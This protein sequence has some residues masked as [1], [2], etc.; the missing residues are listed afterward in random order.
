MRHASMAMSCVAE[1]K[2]DENGKDRNGAEA[3]RGIGTRHQPESQHDQTLAHEHPRPA[4]PEPAGQHGHPRA[5]DERRPEELERGNQR[6]QA[7]EA[8]HF[9]REAGGAQPRRQRV[10]DEIVR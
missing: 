8:D 5:I 2:P 3:A 6:D 7:E 1:A 9:E 10:E 4:M